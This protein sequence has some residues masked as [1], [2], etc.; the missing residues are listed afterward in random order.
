MWWFGEVTDF[1]SLLNR[2]ANLELSQLFESTVKR[3][4]EVTYSKDII[5][6]KQLKVPFK[7]ELVP[8]PVPS[9]N[10]EL[11]A[12]PVPH[13]KKGTSSSSSSF[14]SSFWGSSI[15]KYLCHGVGQIRQQ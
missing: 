1:T 14:S 6:D 2:S 13:P 4:T 5:I 7:K 11:V 9:Q 10:K 8:V 12:P 15:K 3:I